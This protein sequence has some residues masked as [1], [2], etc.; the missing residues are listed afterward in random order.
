MGVSHVAFSQAERPQGHEANQ[1]VGA[2]VVAI[3]PSVNSFTRKVMI[4]ALDK[5]IVWRDDG[6]DPTPTYGQVIFAGDVL[7][8]EAP[9]T[10]LQNFRA[11][12]V[13]G[14]TA[15]VRVAYYGIR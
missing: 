3:L 4:Q 11:R 1:A 5:D 2:T 15:N 7:V 10:A 8:Y 9:L 13:D 12:S 14:T 6:V